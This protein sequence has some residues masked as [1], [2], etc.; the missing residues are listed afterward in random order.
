VSVEDQQADWRDISRHVA[1]DSPHRFI[2]ISKKTLEPDT[3]KFDEMLRVVLLAAVFQDLLQRVRK[4]SEQA[5]KEADQALEALDPYE[6][7][8]AVFKSSAVEGVW[9]PETLVRLY[10]LAEVRDTTQRLRADDEVHELAARIRQMVVAGEQDWTEDRLEVRR[11]RELQRLET[12]QD[13]DAVNQ[14]HLPLELGDV[15]ERIEGGKKFVLLAPP[16]DLVVRRDG[17]RRRNTNTGVLVE[18][19]S[20]DH[21]GSYE[22]FPLP[23]FEL[24]SKAT[25]V[26]DL[27]RTAVVPL[28]VLDLCVFRPDGE[29]SFTVKAQA[30]TRLLPAWDKRYAELKER[31]SKVM[32]ILQAEARDSIA[33]RALLNDLS[34]VGLAGPFNVTLQSDG[35][36]F[37]FRRIARLRPPYANA[38]LSRFANHFSRD[39]FEHD[40]TRTA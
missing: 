29:C 18:L 11:I 16:C 13:A 21:P 22:E 36:R 38:L 32:E 6:L 3:A 40:L 7:E 15:F 25:T 33:S 5:H 34:P 1:P 8:V 31:F 9:E 12:L 24:D 4:A 28:E 23:L 17:Q 19:R 30:P 27:K 26:A 37:G 2:V 14:V 10:E 35:L 20:M 39:A